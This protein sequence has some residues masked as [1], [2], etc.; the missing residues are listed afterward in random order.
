[1]TGSRIARMTGSPIASAFALGMCALL[2]GCG[3]SGSSS[4]PPT[5]AP[6]ATAMT[7]VPSPTANTGSASG[8]GCLPAT[9]DSNGG[10]YPAATSSD[11]TG[12]KTVE[13]DI[14][15]DPKLNGGFSPSNITIAKGT[16]VTWVWKSGGHNLH[17][18]HDGIED[19]GF[20]ISKTFDTAGAYP[21]ACQVHPGQSGIVHVR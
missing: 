1:M 20:K 2:A 6:T 7:V 11:C 18:F 5:V 14:V 9:T 12:N 15:P 8:P 17:P 4:P 19:M 3:G 10:P 21:Y 13:V 16:T